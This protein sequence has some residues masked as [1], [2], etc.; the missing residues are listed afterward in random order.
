MKTL[1][2]LGLP[3]AIILGVIL[4]LIF[5]GCALRTPIHVES[6]FPQRPVVRVCETE[7]KVEGVKDGDKVILPLA[8]A[9]RLR[10]WID[11]LQ[12]CHETNELLLQ[13][14]IEKLEN[15]LKIFIGEKQ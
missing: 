5:S 1:E 14:H 2:T 3:V 15:R 12:I 6:P 13:A 7:P 8:D 10:D 4:G 11:E 9:I